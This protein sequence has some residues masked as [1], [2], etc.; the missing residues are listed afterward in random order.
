MREEAELIT[1]DKTRVGFV[2]LQPLVRPNEQKGPGFF[3]SVGMG[4]METT[5]IPAIIGVAKKIYA[6]NYLETDTPDGWS[7]VQ[8]DHVK[9]IPL[10][11]WDRVFRARSPKEVDIIRR[12][13]QTE[14][15]D[16]E[17]LSSGS[18]IG[19]FIGN[20]GGGLASATSLIPIA[21]QLKY[22]SMAKGFVNNAVRQ[23][24][25]VATAAIIS[26][27]ALV[28][29]SET[30]DLSDWAI[31][32]FVET[33]IASTVFGALGAR[34]A[35]KVELGKRFLKDKYKDI[36]FKEVPNPEGGFKEY[37][38]E[39][40]P[41][42]SAG[43]MLVKEANRD[44]ADGIEKLGEWPG[45]KQIFSASPIV[46]GL[47]SDFETV[48]TWTNTMFR[49]NILTGGGA[50]GE[51]ITRAEDIYKFWQSM[52]M[53][54]EKE[55]G[56]LWAESIGIR[57]AFNN[58]RAA[59]QS[60]L[61]QIKEGGMTR[62]QFEEAMFDPMFNGGVHDNPFV[63]KAAAHVRKE[64]DQMFEQLVEFGILDR[65]INSVTDISY[66]N[67]V[68]NK[69]KMEADPQGFIDTVTE[70]IIKQ[71]T[72]L[73][74]LREPLDFVSKDISELRA[75]RA[76][77]PDAK[78]KNSLTK[79]IKNAL[80][81]KRGVEADIQ[82]RI[83]EKKIGI[84]YLEGKPQLSPEDTMQLNK[85]RKEEVK[86]RNQLVR[87]VNEVRKKVKRL[88]E[89]LRSH[90]RDI[91]ADRKPGQK[92]KAP[93]EKQLSIEAK[94]KEERELLKN[95][96]KS[97]REYDEALDV[98]ISK[99]NYKPE[100][101]SFRKGSALRQFVDLK[102]KPFLRNA[103]NDA[104]ASDTAKQIYHT[105]LQETP[106]QMVAQMGGAVMSG[107]ANPTK[108]RSLLFSTQYL[109]PWLE[110]N[111]N[112]LMHIHTNYVGKLIGFEQAMRSRGF[113][114]KEGIADFMQRLTKEFDRKSAAVTSAKERDKLRNKYEEAKDFINTSY[115]IYWGN[116]RPGGIGGDTGR[117]ID[118][119]LKNLRNYSVSMLG[120]VPFLQLGETFANFFRHGFMDIINDGL[121]P[122]LSSKEFRK[123]SKANAADNALGINTALNYHTQQLWGN[124]AEYQPRSGMQR[125]TGNIAK[126][127]TNLYGINSLA[128][129]NQTMASTISQSKT[130]R[131]LKKYAAGQKLTKKET[132][133]LALMGIEPEL[134]A[135]RILF[136][137]KEHGKPIRE[138]KGAEAY[139][140]NFK[141]WKD[142]GAMQTFMIAVNKEVESVVLS[143][144]MLDTPFA[145][146]NPF[147]GAMTQFMSYG[148]AATN[149]F[150]IPILQR[151]DADK[152][153]GMLGMMAFGAPVGLLRKISAGQ[154]IEEEDLKP[155][156]ILREA[157][158]NSG[159][160][161][162]FADIFE[163]TNAVLDVPFLNKL[164]A[165]RYRNKGV[166]ELLAGPLGGILNAAV[167]TASMFLN[168]NFNE[169]QARRSIR[170]LMPG[171][172]ALW[173]RGLIN[174]R[175][176][177][178]DLPK[179]KGDASKW[180]W[181][182]D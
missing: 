81:K 111:V 160:L 82:A 116:Y 152:L 16:K 59:L 131:T 13:I 34:Q 61:K 119:A 112:S 118:D 32:T 127:T 19:A 53:S 153:I 65:N 147:I 94:L 136:Q 86:A 167:D 109:K 83:D 97:L 4:F 80:K 132:E 158:V 76:A 134:W 14:L 64:Y 100:L 126:L 137:F 135:D 75:Q 90:K 163:K 166:P 161:G 72:E 154:E 30:K 20:I 146:R 98:K 148:F 172:S 74:R 89:D 51:A 44:L 115:Q 39:A 121:L 141:D 96:K 171:A 57:G 48:K 144:N 159:V 108:A 84:E 117:N 99:G 107:G 169:A 164:K 174:N 110:T 18:G 62:Q 178:M 7:A 9:D 124:G 36:D 104:D 95:R 176:E 133:R 101:L 22:A 93:D 105:I 142:F 60:A 179:T 143:P 123:M 25:G 23:F 139:Q 88:E 56:D 21:G 182:E 66:I 85:L 47:T 2:N 10:E 12:S 175:I 55:I 180:S 58:T 129:W 150:L 113:N 155:E 120:G 50:K 173:L 125:F 27:A 40:T 43:A 145:F 8:E 63:M 38:A 73:R 41:G 114:S 46:R 54:N 106:E 78:L 17:Y 151:P 49:H 3:E 1:P 42:G 138:G 102:K 24:P 68:Y 29:N 6:D 31:D 122:Y 69:A 177:A 71:N 5:D 33:A 26:N 37:I 162:H 35:R 92:N 70:Q 165:D 128:D 130:I 52:A 87:P 181:I 140:A 45:F 157:V 67:R 77:T 168:G 28:A 91:N 103:G 170:T 156:S 79:D 15:N 11:Y 149:S